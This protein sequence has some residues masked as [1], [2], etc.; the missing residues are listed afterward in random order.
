MQVGDKLSFGSY[1]FRVLDIQNDRALIIT[2]CIIEHHPY[3]DT[4]KDTTWA[5]CSLRNYLNSKFYDKFDA[6]DKSRIMPIINE[7]PD[8]QWYGTKGGAATED[9]IF[10]LSLEEVAC[11]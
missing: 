10:L 8:N 2:E 11:Q 9:Y 7:N 6:T 1:D 3:H 4:Y 5:E